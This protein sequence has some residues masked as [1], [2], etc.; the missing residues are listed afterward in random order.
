MRTGSFN[1]HQVIV[2]VMNLWSSKA[3]NRNGVIYIYLKCLE[4]YGIRSIVDI[5]NQP[6][7]LNVIPSFWKRKTMTPHLKPGK[8]PSVAGSYR[9]SYRA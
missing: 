6:F 4:P 9:P 5:H 3:T 1:L 7:Q 2:A 8:S